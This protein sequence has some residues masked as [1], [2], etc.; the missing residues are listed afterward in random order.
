M[1]NYS[2]LLTRLTRPIK[3]TS[4]KMLGYACINLTLRKD[5]VFASRG[6]TLGTLNKLGERDAVAHCKALA[7]QNIADL[8]TILKWN[9]AHDI[10]LFRITSVLFPHMGNHFVRYRDP[11]F[12]GDIEFAKQALREV[13]EYARAHG[14]RLTFHA[15]PYVQFGSPNPEIV[16]RSMFD[17]EMHARVLEIVGSP[18]SVIILHGGGVY[19][20]GGDKATAKAETLKRWLSTYK[21]MSRAAQ[22][23]IALENDERHYG[24]AD[25]LP[26]CEA[27]GI[28]FCLDHFHNNISADRLDPIPL[29]PRIVATWRGSRP[30]FHMSDQKPNSV[31]GAHA[32]MVKSLPDYLKKYDVMIE[33]KNKELAVLHL[34]KTLKSLTKKSDKKV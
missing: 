21:R 16:A 17:V 31:F 28:R 29:L 20:L 18:D 1:I 34:L 14:H 27:N 22:G 15:Q 13:G 30:K 26:F 8:L 9:E 11:Y 25:L 5:G 6:C 32:D 7:L 4:K 12:R 3:T 24:V 19:S 33:A 2:I 23:W 10:R